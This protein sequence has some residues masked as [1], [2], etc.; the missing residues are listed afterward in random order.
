MV[1]LDSDGDKDIIAGNGT[2]GLEIMYKNP[3]IDM[4]LVPIGGGGLITGIG[5]AAKALN[6]EVKI[7]GIQTEKCPAMKKSIDEGILYREFPTENS[8][9]DALIGGVGKIP[10]EMSSECI[11]DILLVSE[12]SIMNAT[13]LLLTE[14]K[15]VAEPSSSLGVAALMEQPEYFEGKNIAIVITGGNL[16]KKMLKKLLIDY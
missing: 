7:I 2:V 1:F 11:D 3:A 9:C 8:V 13:S 16:D 15:I 4:I 14:E 10:F 12:E 6:P 5:V